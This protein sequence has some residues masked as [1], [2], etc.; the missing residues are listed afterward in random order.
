MPFVI[1]YYLNPNFQYKH[2]L[3]DDPNLIQVVHKVYMQLDPNAH[4]ISNFGI[5][6][7]F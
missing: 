7:Q 6:V 3:G 5:E 2:N 4:G 1:A